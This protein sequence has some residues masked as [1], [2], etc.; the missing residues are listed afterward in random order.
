MPKFQITSPDGQKFEVNAPEGAT[1]EQVLAYAQSQFQQKKP[2]AP[3]VPANMGVAANAGNKAIAAL[4]DTILNTPTN[5]WNLAKSGVVGAGRAMGYDTHLPYTE[6]PNYA[7]K[8]MEKLRL[9]DPAYDPKTAGQRMLAAGTGGAVSAAMNPASS[10]KQLAA[11]LGSGA[12]A[13]LAGQGTKEVTGS[14]TAGMAASMLTP[15][16]VNA[17][18]TGAQNKISQMAS[19]RVRNA[20]RDETLTRAMDE[21][22]LVPPSTVNPT[23]TNKVLESIS[24]KAAT[25]QAVSTQNAAVTDRLARRSIGLADD[26]P[27]TAEATQNIRREAYDRGYRPLKDAG[28]ISTG[29]T[30]R[31]ALD[32]IEAQYQGAA[33][34]F[35]EAV[36]N[37]VSELIQSLRR[38][39]FDAGDA[40]DMTRTLREEASKSFRSGDNAL[41]NAQRAAAKAIEDQIELGL[42]AKTNS[43]ELLKNFRDARQ[44]MAKTHTVE[45]AIKEGGGNVDANK[46]ARELQKGAPL[47]G[48]LETIGRFA[49]VYQKSNQT[50]QVVGSQGVSKTAALASALFGSGGAAVAGPVG[51]GAAALPFVVPPAV[52][53]LILSKRFQGRQIPKYEASLLAKLLAD[54]PDQSLG[55]MLQQQQMA[56]QLKRGQ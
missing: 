40:V 42:S 44:L 51:V 2:E 25:Q 26:A 54:A 21:G 43:P 45:D 32:A 39:S 48:D 34:S 41:G 52:E 16:A 24:G 11:L 53:K 56:E 6:P 19:D 30:Y 28:Q 15:M 55:A 46:I 49:N 3:P 18:R 14:D 17:A 8:G 22:Y 20:P 7:Q 31:Q 5:L 27:L 37:D 29:K 35:P 9:I 10:A 13:G 33:R 50:P 36:R 23:R 12:T 1:Q 4:P 47:T 38:R